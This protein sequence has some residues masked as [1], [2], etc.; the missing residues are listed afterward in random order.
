M[1][2]TIKTVAMSVV[3][4][5]VLGMTGMS[6][7]QAADYNN[8]SSYNQNNSSMNNGSQNGI[9]PPVNRGA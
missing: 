4:G 5:G 7:A 9:V 2:K 3:L 8:G 6:M 1:N